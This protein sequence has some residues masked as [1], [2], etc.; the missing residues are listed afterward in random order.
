MPHLLIEDPHLHPGVP[1]VFLEDARQSPSLELA[2]TSHHRTGA[3][4]SHVAAYEGRERGRLEEE[5]E[6]LDDERFWGR[7]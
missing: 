1:P 6:G 3:V 2:I 7:R 4:T 5:G